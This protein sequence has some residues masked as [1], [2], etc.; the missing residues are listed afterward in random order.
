MPQ[1]MM[2]AEVG[3]MMFVESKARGA[4]FYEERIQIHALDAICS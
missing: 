4:A 3:K 1:V 2:P